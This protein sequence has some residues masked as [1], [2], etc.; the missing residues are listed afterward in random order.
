MISNFEKSIL[1]SQDNMMDEAIDEEQIR[2]I[3]EFSEICQMIL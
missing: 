2:S 3:K 1:V